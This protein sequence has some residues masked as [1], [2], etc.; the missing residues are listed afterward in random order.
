MIPIKIEVCDP[1]AKDGINRY[2]MYT[3]KGSD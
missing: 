2:I 3:I 1:I